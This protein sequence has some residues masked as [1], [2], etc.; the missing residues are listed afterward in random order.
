MSKVL[1]SLPGGLMKNSVIG[2]ILALMCY[3]LLQFLAA[4][5]IHSEIVGEGAIYLMVCAAAGLS[6]FLGCAYCVIKGGDGRVLSASAVV[7]VFLAVTVAVGLLTGEVG[8]INGGLTGVGA[9]MAA[10]GLLAALVPELRA[11]KGKTRRDMPKT[12]RAR[13]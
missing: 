1:A 8:T 10:G 11:K 3:V 5:L 6:S 12:R 4:L 13:K 2:A 7:L 9:S